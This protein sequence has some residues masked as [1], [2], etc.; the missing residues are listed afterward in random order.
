[1]S[2]SFRL[3]L[4]RFYKRWIKDSIKR[5]ISDKEIKI[6]HLQNSAKLEQIFWGCNK[7]ETIDEN[8]NIKIEIS[9]VIG[10]IYN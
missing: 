9:E 4:K 5:H 1:M 7:C 10:D 8:D 6:I 2:E 3:K